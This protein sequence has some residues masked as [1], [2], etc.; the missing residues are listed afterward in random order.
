[1]IC[2]PTCLD[3]LLPPQKAVTTVITLPMGSRIVGIVDEKEKKLKEGMKM[4]GLSDFAYWMS[5][6]ASHGVM[7][8]AVALLAAVIM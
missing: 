4:M 8:F 1:M 6:V 5:W 3:P 2:P 7:M